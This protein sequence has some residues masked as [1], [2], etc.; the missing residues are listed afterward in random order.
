[1]GSTL[2]GS[3]VFKLTNNFQNHADQERKTLV[4]TKN[5]VFKKSSCLLYA[6]LQFTMIKIRTPLLINQYVTYVVEQCQNRKNKSRFGYNSRLRQFHTIR[7]DIQIVSQ[8]DL[9]VLVQNAIRLFPSLSYPGLMPF[10][11]SRNSFAI[12]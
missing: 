12:D 3:Q 1:M 10:L 5:V 7:F 2:F 4:Q 11:S 6:Y 9:I 8:A